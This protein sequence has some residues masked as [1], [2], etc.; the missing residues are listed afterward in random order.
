MGV[1]PCGR[2][3]VHQHFLPPVY[4]EALSRAGLRTVDGGMPVPA[5]SEAA[6]LEM[7]DRQGIETAMVSLSSPS[8]H[9]LPLAERP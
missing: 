1:C 9:F 8:A 4:A 3:D 6:A 2:I 7:M 5:W